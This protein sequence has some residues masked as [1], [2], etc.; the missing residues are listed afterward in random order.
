M[1]RCLIVG[2]QT[3]GSDALIKVIKDKLNQG[4]REFFVLAPKTKPEHEASEWTGGYFE[5]ADTTFLV[6]ESRAFREQM[7]AMR[8]AARWRAQDR[9]ELVLEL[10]RAAGGQAEGELGVPDPVEA[11]QSV[12]GT[13][14]PFDEIVI[15]TLP[16]G[17]S[18]W[19]DM[20]LANRIG[21]ITTAKIT[22]IH[23][24]D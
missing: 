2:N 5:G 11:V 8:D 12:L 15:S 10:I 19:F 21:Q 1:T 23:A 4:V 16:G 18:H 22:T 13:Q 3:L 20:D 6:G 7:G 24:P 14:P 9:L 17:L